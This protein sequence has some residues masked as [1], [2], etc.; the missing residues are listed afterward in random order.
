MQKRLA[1][2]WSPSEALPPV[3]FKLSVH[4]WRWATSEGPTATYLISSG[5]VS[6]AETG[7]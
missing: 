7:I 6:N 1:Q 5:S 4:P 2:G 3:R